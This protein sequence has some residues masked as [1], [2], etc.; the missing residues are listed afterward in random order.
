MRVLVLYAC[1]GSLWNQKKKMKKK[2]EDMVK[3]NDDIGKMSQN[4]LDG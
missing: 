3:R 1:A 4:E 2:S